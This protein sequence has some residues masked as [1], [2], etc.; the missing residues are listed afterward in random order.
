MLQLYIHSSHVL[1]LCTFCLYCLLFRIFISTTAILAHLLYPSIILK[2][3]QRSI[4][5]VKYAPGGPYLSHVL[6]SCT[7]HRHVTAGLGQH[8]ND[9]YSLGI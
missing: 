2:I 8:W 5:H 1:L 7:V 4:Y 9:N 3:D 6:V